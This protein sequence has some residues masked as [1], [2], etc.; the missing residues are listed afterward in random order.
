MCGDCK[1]EAD[2]DLTKPTGKCNCTLCSKG[3][4]W[5]TRCEPDQF[6]LISGDLAEYIHKN[7]EIRR[8]FCKKCG[9]TLCAKFNFPHL[10]GEKVSPNLACLDVTPEDWAKMPVRYLDG[11]ND[12]W[13]NEPKE[14]S[15][16]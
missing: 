3:R 10:G 5:S 14:T 8:Y 1:F 16:M 6:N 15:Y 2:L 7:P 12:N 4:Y 11:L 9:I 13:M